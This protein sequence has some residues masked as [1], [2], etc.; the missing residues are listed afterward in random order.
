[1]DP[2]RIVVLD[3]D[4]SVQELLCDLVEQDGY[5]ANVADPAGGLLTQLRAR[6]PALLIVDIAP[7]VQT[8]R[9][10]LVEQLRRDAR[11]RG[12]PILVTTTDTRW[13]ADHEMAL[14]ALG[15]QALLKP[16]AV[17]TFYDIL[18]TLL[19]EDA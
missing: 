10:R 6:P 8:R 13:L 2:S 7:P 3:E 17:T 12:L 4:P 5:L 15:V 19:K 1:M 14:T 16:F 11:T 18:E 9:W